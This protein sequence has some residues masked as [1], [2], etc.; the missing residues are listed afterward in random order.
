M[1]SLKTLK[2]EKFLNGLMENE[3]GNIILEVTGPNEENIILNY[4][5]NIEELSWMSRNVSFCSF[6]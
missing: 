5:K 6:L 2:T 4:T 1:E 3:N